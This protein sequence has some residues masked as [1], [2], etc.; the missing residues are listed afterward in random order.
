M[1][2]VLNSFQKLEFDK[3]KKYI[4]RYSISDLGREQIEQLTPSTDIIQIRKSLSLVSE[5]KQLLE[6]DDLLPIE[7]IFDVRTSILRSTIGD[8]IL[9]TEELHKI[10]LLLKTSKNI[11][12]Y[13]N[14]RAKLYPLLFE[15]V[16]GIHIEK[17]LEYNIHQAID[18]DSRVKDDASKELLSIRRQIID[19]SHSIKRSLE[20]LLK[21]IVGADWVQEEIITTREG[22]MVIPVKVE[23]K[24]R[25]PGFIHSASAS[26]AT[27]YIEPAETLEMN[28]EIRTLSFQEQREIDKI[29]KELTKQ[30]SNVK[31]NIHCNIQIL[32][33]IDFIQSKAKYSIQVIGAEPKMK[34]DGAIRYLNAYHPILLQRHGRK[35]IVPLNMGIPPEINTIII[36]GPNAGGKSVAMKTVGLLSMLAQSGC[37]IPASP[38][39]ELKIFS[40]YFVDIGDEQSIENDLSSFS[41]HLKNLK[42]IIENANPSSLILLDEIGSGTDPV[43]GSSLAAAIL[44]QLTQV[45]SLNIA[46]THHGTLKSF[47]FETLG[48]E[49]SAMEFDID[50]LKP[51]YKFRFGIPGSSYAIEMAERLDMP[52]YIINRSREFKGSESSKLENLIIDLERQSQELKSNLDKVNQDKIHLDGLNIVYQT[53]ITTLEKELNDIKSRALDEAKHIV[54]KANTIIENSIREI[55]E[56]SADRQVIKRAKEE[57]KQVSEEF[58]KQL[59]DIQSAPDEIKFHLGDRVRLKQSN[60]IGEIISIIDDKSFIVLTGDLRMKVNKRDLKIELIAKSSLLKQST[61]IQCVPDKFQREIDLRGM[62]GDEAITAV[63]KFID[64]AILSGLNRIDIIHGKGTGVLRKKITE[65]LKNNPSII[66]YRLGEW[67]EGGSGVTVVELK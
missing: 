19:R 5:M 32:S 36:T 9:S 52:S 7:N 42:F 12:T 10:E 50:T 11:V 43:E 33:D 39:S 20:S 46:T 21:S 3:V 15:R 18:D 13:F 8:Y 6:S 34:T 47:A 2:D 29:L 62:Y 53:K 58:T 1:H 65:Y 59:E 60:T 37:H 16:K 66:S 55:K 63:D 45:K 40:D 26:V 25:L 57:I 27:V 23:Y 22:R 41:S 38:E 28:N 17:I 14:R 54:L 61:L 44:E 4:Q 31:D 64:S 30:V 67:N 49:N 48:I 24:N 51:T 56:K 35:D